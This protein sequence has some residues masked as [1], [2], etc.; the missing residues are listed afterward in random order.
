[1]SAVGYQVPEHQLTELG[2]SVASAGTSGALHHLFFAVVGGQMVC[3]T[4][5]PNHD[6]A[7]SRLPV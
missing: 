6:V 3:V 1:M 5:I 7:C 2:N 4:A